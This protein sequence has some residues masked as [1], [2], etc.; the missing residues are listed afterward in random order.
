VYRQG[1]FPLSAQVVQMTFRHTFVEERDPFTYRVRVFGISI[2]GVPGRLMYDSGDVTVGNQLN[3][4]RS[5][6]QGEDIVE[7]EVTQGNPFARW[8]VELFC[9]E[10][11]PLP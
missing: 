2:R 5:K 4:C 1:F 11:N 7:V 6:L 8:E 10:C 9:S 3:V